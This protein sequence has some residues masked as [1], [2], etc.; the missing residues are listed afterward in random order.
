M[1]IT[2][3]CHSRQRHTYMAGRTATHTLTH[4]GAIAPG[5]FLS[6]DP[7]DIND[8]QAFLVR[9]KS[10][11]PGVRTVGVTSGDDLVRWNEPERVLAAIRSRYIGD[12][13]V[14]IVLVGEKT[15]TRRF[16]DWEV[17][18]SANSGCALVAIPLFAGSAAPARVRLLAED[19]SALILQ[20][21]PMSPREL[22]NWIATALQARHADWGGRAMHTPLMRRD[23]SALT[24]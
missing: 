10:V 4:Q 20:R 15:W 2:A 3:V 22:S 24:A 13:T 23:A 16:I 18:A 19:G 11:L 21:P 5:A 14:T 17:A 7:R 6:F 1:P 9:N 8:V 12:A